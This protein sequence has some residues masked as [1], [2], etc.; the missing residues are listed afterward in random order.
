MY[1]EEYTT[2]RNDMHTVRHTCML[3]RQTPTCVLGIHTCKYIHIHNT[4]AFEGT[5][6]I[7][8]HTDTTAFSHTQP[9][10]RA[11]IFSHTTWTRAHINLLQAEKMADRSSITRQRPLL[12]TLTLGLFCF[13][14]GFCRKLAV[15]VTMSSALFCFPPPRH[16]LSPP[17]GL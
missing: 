3:H 4:H 6:N 11:H 10:I 5:Y 7:Q 9:S 14:G 2:S 17:Y 12:P 1:T 16:P 8:T 13:V 15:P